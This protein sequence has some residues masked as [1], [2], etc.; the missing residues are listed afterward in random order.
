MSNLTRS[1]KRLEA[2]AKKYIES[3][4]KRVRREKYENWTLDMLMEATTLEIYFPDVP[5]D[6]ID[7]D[8]LIRGFRLPSGDQNVIQYGC[9]VWGEEY[10]VNPFAGLDTL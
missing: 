8:V 1:L 5:K 3:K 4:K 7:Q 6:E 2:Y 10:Y 9:R